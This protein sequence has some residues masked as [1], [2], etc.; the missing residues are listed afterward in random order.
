MISFRIKNIKIT[1]DMGFLAM[2][3]MVSMNQSRLYMYAF[4]TCIIHELGHMIQIMLTGGNVE[5]IAFNGAGIKIIPCR[6][7]LLSVWD[8]ISVLL[9]GSFVNIFTALILILINH[10]QYNVF[11]YM[12]L[13][14]G[15]LNLLPFRCLDGGAVILCLAEHFAAYDKHLTIMKFLKVFNII[16]CII[17]VFSFRS[18]I[19]QNISAI[20]MIIYLIISEILK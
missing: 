5:K 17:L 10:G 18:F 4:L 12:N 1:A 14:L 11:I 3:A 13:I 19:M 20:V 8:D 16:L 2:L 6:T 15:I 9:G 7:R